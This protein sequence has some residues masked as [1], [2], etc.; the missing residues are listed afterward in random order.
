M[1][2]I[3]DHW[4][5]L[6]VISPPTGYDAA[7]IRAMNDGYERIWE[8]GERYALVSHSPPSA[9]AATGAR[10]RKLIAEW[11]NSPRVRRMS[12]EM[13]VGSATI[14]RS[15]LARGSLTALLWLWSPSSP[16]HVAASPEE[17]VDW[18][19]GQLANAKVPLQ[20]PAADVRRA[21]LALMRA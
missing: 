1:Q 20:A 5:L 10:S 9:E 6:I 17:A 18:C 12:K 8:K 15:A 21:A 2:F 3:L 13:C 7:T 19:L 4:P 14:V 11:A 16:H